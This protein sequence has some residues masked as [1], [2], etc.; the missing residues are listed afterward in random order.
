MNHRILKSDKTT[1][2]KQ[3]VSSQSLN[4]DKD[5]NNDEKSSTL[6]SSSC[7]RYRSGKLKLALD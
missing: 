1:S 6:V 5:K 4:Y 2:V 3:M 7:F